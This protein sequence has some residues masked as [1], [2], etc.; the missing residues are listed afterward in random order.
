MLATRTTEKVKL[1]V[2]REAAVLAD[3]F[4]PI[5]DPAKPSKT[6]IGVYRPRNITNPVAIL[7]KG[8]FALAPRKSE[9]LFAAADVNSYIIWVKPCGPL[10]PSWATAP[11][12]YARTVGI[13]IIRG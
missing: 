1:P 13:I 5:I 3:R 11:L 12:E 6:A 9:P 4:L 2:R 7:K 10:K 8:V